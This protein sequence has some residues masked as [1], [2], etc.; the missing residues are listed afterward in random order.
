M[1]MPRR[2]ITASLHF[3]LAVTLQAW[4]F[5][6]ISGSTA[7]LTAIVAWARGGS[8]SN[9]APLSQL[10][11]PFCNIPC[12]LGAIYHSPKR[13]FREKVN[14][15]WQTLWV[16]CDQGRPTISGL[17]HLINSPFLSFFATECKRCKTIFKKSKDARLPAVFREETVSLKYG[18]D[19]A[20]Q[21]VTEKKKER[22]AYC[23]THYHLLFFLLVWSLWM[24][25]SKESIQQGFIVILKNKVKCLVGEGSARALGSSWTS[26]WL[27]LKI[28]SSVNV[29]LIVFNHFQIA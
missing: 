27:F 16:C 25:L 5:G 12:R 20:R 23:L 11:I 3:P 4:Q 9:I 15:L 21:T 22:S 18:G 10:R 1:L 8:E 29:L 28:A 6:V 2:R 17:C 14:E 7:P 26:C 19:S 24:T 13:L